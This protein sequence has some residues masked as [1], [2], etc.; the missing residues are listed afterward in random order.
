M[1]AINH[2]VNMKTLAAL[3]RIYSAQFELYEYILHHGIS[4]GYTE[5]TFMRRTLGDLADASEK[6][7]AH[8]NLNTY[9]DS[10]FMYVRTALASVQNSL[11]V[12]DRLL[13]LAEEDN[14]YS[15]LRCSDEFAI[16]NEKLH[17]AIGIANKAA[18][19]LNVRLTEGF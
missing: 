8:M 19:I 4:I 9:H 6:I 14:R 5:D 12:F 13:Q 3:K 1:A 2:K 17:N 15:Q 11:S 18:D 10:M 16:Y 7:L